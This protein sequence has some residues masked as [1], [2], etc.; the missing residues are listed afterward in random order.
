MPATA[1]ALIARYREADL[2][3]IYRDVVGYW[4]EVL[5]AVQV[6]TPDRS[7]DIMLN[8][9]LLYQTLACRYWARSAFY[10]ASG[11]YGF[12]DQL[13]DVMALAVARPDFTREHI[14]RAAS[15]QFVEGD[16]Q[17]WWFPPAGQGVRTRISDDRVWLAYVTAHYV[18]VT[19]DASI[20][21]ERVPFLE[22][23]PLKP[24]EHD[25]YYVPSVSDEQGTLFEHCARGLDLALPV[26]EHGLPLMGTGDWND[27]MN[28]VGEDGKG[29]SVWLG[30]FL[31]TTLKIFAPVAEQRD[32]PCPWP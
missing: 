13:Q 11:A 4:D 14:L 5:G 30:W 6:T 27:G 25:A 12:R 22:G 8:G 32:R 20:L 7:M 23:P 15:R 16:V 26:G 3:A 29:E 17:H 10:Q 2:D 18:E 19:G 1:R 9:W 21:D 24:G 31:H 28:R